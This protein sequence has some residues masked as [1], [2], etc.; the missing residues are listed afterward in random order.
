MSQEQYQQLL[1]L[2]HD[3][4]LDERSR[5]APDKGPI[6]RHFVEQELFAPMARVMDL[7]SNRIK[8][9]KGL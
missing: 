1:Q 9:L 4:E 7:V 3:M 5:I 8:C 2:L 6:Y